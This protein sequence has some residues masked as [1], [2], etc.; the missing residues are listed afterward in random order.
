M[1]WKGRPNQPILR[2]NT[3]SL[4]ASERRSASSPWRAVPLNK[5]SLPEAPPARNKGGKGKGKSGKGVK[6]VTFGQ[7][8]G[9][10]GKGRKGVPSHLKPMTHGNGVNRN[11]WEVLGKGRQWRVSA[12][13]REIP[14]LSAQQGG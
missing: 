11:Y 9:T 8:G 2:L 5:V 1:G 13:G 14:R 6:G 10:K 7:C 3:K 12:P 4:C